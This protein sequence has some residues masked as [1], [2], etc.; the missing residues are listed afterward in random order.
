MARFEGFPTKKLEILRTASALYSKLNSI[1]TQLETWK[2]EAPLDKLLDRVE[3]YF[4]KVTRKNLASVCEKNIYLN[5]HAHHPYPLTLHAH[6]SRQRLMH[7]NGPKT[8]KL[9]DFRVTISILTSTY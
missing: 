9:N 4:N 8:M 2:I 1:V 3:C 5:C 7:W 6:R